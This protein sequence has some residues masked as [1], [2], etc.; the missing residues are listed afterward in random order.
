M[1]VFFIPLFFVFFGTGTCVLLSKRSFGEIMPV[2]LMGTSLVLMIF[3]LWGNL[4][5]GVYVLLLFS[6][7]F[8]ILLIAFWIRPSFPIIPIFLRGKDRKFDKGAFL[9]RYCSASFFIMLFI[10]IVLFFLHRNMVFTNWDEFMHWGP[11]V[12]EM[13]RLNDFYSVPESVLMHHKDY[14][15]VVPLFEYLWCKIGRGYSEGAMYHSLHFMMF[16]FFL[17][18][19][20]NFKLRKNMREYIKLFFSLVLIAEIV[21][22]FNYTFHRTVYIDSFLGILIA[23]GLAVILFE[24]KMSGFNITRLIILS[25]FLLLTKQIAI[26]FFLLILVILL[27]NQFIRSEG[28]GIGGRVRVIR[29]YLSNGKRLFLSCLSLILLIAIPMLL[30]GAWDYYV[31]SNAIDRQFSTAGMSL[32]SIYEILVNGNGTAV[33]MTTLAN[34]KDF[35]INSSVTTFPFFGYSIDVTCWQAFIALASMFVFLAVLAK[36]VFKRAQIIVTGIILML[37]NIAYTFTML[38]LYLFSFDDYEAPILASIER[39]LNTYNTA[40]LAFGVMIFVYIIWQKSLNPYCALDAGAKKSA[41][42]RRGFF[43]LQLA[44]SVTLVV[45]LFGTGQD[46]LQLRESRGAPFY[47]DVACIRDYTDS[48]GA[49]L[50]VASD[51]FAYIDMVYELAPQSISNY[52]SNYSDEVPLDDWLNDLFA[53]GYD[54]L[55]LQDI[56]QDFIDA[57]ESA[58]DEEMMNGQIYQIE[59]NDERVTGFILLN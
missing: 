27:V 19:F 48:D 45:S 54:Y 37:G 32:K 57:R 2:F 29:G 18:A 24:K 23:Y 51:T 50:L 30:R 20:E 49:V 16:S 38:L 22:I 39:Y 17:P 15:P 55:Y 58:F 13:Y 42:K 43:I 40:L 8:P 33:Q 11:M 5:L 7:V 47:E 21:V 26:I 34:F 9:K 31:D 3:G 35:I 59:K 28:N 25:S 1:T 56:D 36:G 53:R 4:L 46:L 10:Y 14:P 52:T 12:K 6:A 41:W 44:I